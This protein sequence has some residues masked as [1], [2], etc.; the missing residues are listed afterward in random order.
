M[1]N[2]INRITIRQPNDFHCHLRDK[3]E[4]ELNV[5]ICFS[6]FHYIIV[7]PNLEVPI[8]SIDMALDYRKRIMDFNFF[9]KDKGKGIPLMTLYLSK[10]LDVNEI[11][12]IKDYDCIIGIKY[13]P[14]GMTT[15]SEHGVSNVIEII[16]QLKAMEEEGIPLLIHPETANEDIDIFDR[17]THFIQNELKII[18]GECPNLRIV[19]EHISTKGAVDYVL[20][21]KNNKIAATIT[22]HHLVLNRND[23]FTNGK[24]NPF[25]YCCPI[26]KRKEDRDSL[27]KIA[28]SGNRKFFLGT[29]NAPHTEWNKLNNGKAGIFNA[30]VAIELITE[31]FD[32]HNS[33]ENLEKFISTNGTDFYHLEPCSDTITLVKRPWTV[34]DKYCN[35]HNYY[36]PLYSNREIEWEIEWEIE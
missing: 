7:M 28:T 1:N 4:L 3:Q 29:D 15:N 5:N 16:P 26:I 30:P 34:P 27:I 20:N 21:N 18:R 13:Y 2:K 10:N 25:N 12:K 17:E 32:R 14:K 23:I 11:R 36:V 24:L 8:T 35:F 33:L 19:L 6:K 31:L 9:C 22:P